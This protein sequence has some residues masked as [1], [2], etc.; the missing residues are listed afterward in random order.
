MNRYE[1]GFQKLEQLELCLK[2]RE[3]VWKPR[4]MHEATDLLPIFYSLLSLPISTK[5]IDFCA[6]VLGID[7]TLG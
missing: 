5:L 6:T 3:T 1:I 4:K 7:F 2:A